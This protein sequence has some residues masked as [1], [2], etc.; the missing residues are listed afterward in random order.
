[1]A[2][3]QN[4]REST[5]S[6]TNHTQNYDLPLWTEG[7]KTSW[8]T[9]VNDA[10]NKIDSGMVDAKSKALEVVGIAADAKKL[11]EETSA[12]SRES[13]NTVAG[14][15]DRLTAVESTS[16]EHTNDITAL[17]TR[18]DQMDVEIHSVKERQKKTTEDLGTLADQVKHN[19]EDADATK[20]SVSVLNGNVVELTGRVT[21]CEDDIEALKVTTAANTR[22]I[23]QAEENVATVSAKVTAIE[24]EMGELSTATQSNTTAIGAI[25]GNIESIRTKDTTQD[26]QID[27]INT[28]LS[29]LDSRVSTLED[30][31]SGT[32]KTVLMCAKSDTLSSVTDTNGTAQFSGCTLGAFLYSDGTCD[33]TLSSGDT[34]PFVTGASFTG[35]IGMFNL[36]EAVNE[37]MEKFRA[38]YPSIA[39]VRQ[40]PQHA[41]PMV[42]YNDG[43]VPRYMVNCKISSLFTP[44]SSKMMMTTS[45]S[46][47]LSALSGGTVSVRYAFPDGEHEYAIGSKQNFLIASVIVSGV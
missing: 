25:N 26:G 39:I 35:S 15:N 6:T 36:T 24:T 34:Y 21:T 12:E 14:Y 47:E 8:L 11:A 18:C 32:T 29:A 13:A 3:N 41:Y 43:N 20:Q 4:F 5:V 42:I 44:T 22:N 7:D 46:L 40:V 31:A 37:I 2:I 23:A 33:F 10:M 27:A 1:M 38:K 17:N 28:D 45:Y 9:Q 30:G 16:V 19:K